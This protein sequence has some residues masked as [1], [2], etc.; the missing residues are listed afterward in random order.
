MR[1]TT[2]LQLQRHLLARSLLEVAAEQQQC[3][4]FIADIY[5]S[6]IVASWSW[7]RGRPCRLSSCQRLFCAI[8]V[9]VFLEFAA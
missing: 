6:T 3:S 2:L 4:R 5:V 7:I 8:N 1:R 9:H